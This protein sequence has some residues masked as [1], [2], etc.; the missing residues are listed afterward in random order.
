MSLSR[1]MFAFGVLASCSTDTNTSDRPLFPDGFIVFQ[2]GVLDALD[3]TKIDNPNVRIEVGHT[4]LPAE[5]V[6]DLQV[7]YGVPD[8]TEVFVLSDAAGYAPFIA[9]ISINGV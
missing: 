9:K 1:A 5:V 6:N 7:I 4:T 2:A 3:G 8:A